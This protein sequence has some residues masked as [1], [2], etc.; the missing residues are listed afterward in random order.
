TVLVQHCAFWDRDGDGIIWPLDTFRGF[1]ELGYNLLLSIIAVF[2]IHTGFSYPTRLQ[3][4]LVPDPLFRV[5][6][7][8]IHKAKHGSDTGTYNSQGYFQPQVFEGI[9]NRYSASGDALTVRE[10]FNLIKGQ[11][12]AMDPFGWFA[13]GFEFYTL[14]LSTYDAKSGVCPKDSIRRLYDGSFFWHVKQC[15]E[16]GRGEQ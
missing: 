2:V 13:A 9:F 16:T 5:Y 10:V 8:G 14:V 3:H 12:V 7:D 1:R 6:L 11:R 4:S 15:R